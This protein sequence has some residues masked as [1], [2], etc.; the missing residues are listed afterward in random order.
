M[1]L[2]SYITNIP[3]P[4]NN[5]QTDVPNMQINTNSINSWVGVDHIGFNTSGPAGVSG[6]FHNVVHL[7]TQG[8]I[9]ND[10]TLVAG[11]GELYTKT[12]SS[13]VI[14]LFYRQ[15]NGFVNQ[16]TYVN[17]LSFASPGYVTVT[18]G[19]VFMWGT[20]SISG[21]ST[22]VSFVPSIFTNVFNIQL[23]G[24]NVGT[25]THTDCMSV[26]PGS[27]STSGFTAIYSGGAAFNSFY[28]LAIG[29]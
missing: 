4:P 12:D 28:W 13:S 29:N 22:N 25:N 19:A 23:T 9:A 18:G 17:S 7:A 26:Q 15:S 10:P 14:Q 24:I 20:K 27:V 21:T 6:G 5:P 2:I 1:T 11:T 8:G 16:L 3:N